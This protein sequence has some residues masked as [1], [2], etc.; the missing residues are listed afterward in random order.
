MDEQQEICK[1]VQPQ[2]KYATALEICWN[3]VILAARSAMY[4]IG[5]LSSLWASESVNIYG[6]AILVN[7]YLFRWEDLHTCGEVNE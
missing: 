3:F 7:F 5:I 4:G 6:I 1:I 2:W